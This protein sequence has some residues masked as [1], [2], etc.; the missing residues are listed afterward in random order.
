MSTVSCSDEF[1]EVAPAGSLSQTELATLS[2]LE[3]TLLGAYSMLLGRGGFY[4]AADNWVW[5]SILGGDAN[6]GT[7][8]G[9]QSQINEIQAY[10]VQTNNA[11]VKQKYQNS[12]EGVARANAVLQLIALAEDV[13]E[14]D[15]TRI[16]A[17]ARFLRGHYYFDLKKNFNNVPYVDENWDEIEP[18][19]NNQDLYPFI[20]A[21][22][23]F[24]K[25]NLPETMSDLVGL[26]E[27]PPLHIWE[28]PY[29]SRANGL[30]PKPNLIRSLMARVLLLKAK[31]THCYRTMGMPSG[32]PW[33][34]AVNRCLLPRQQPILGVLTMPTRQWY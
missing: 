26:T 12:Y 32:H 22:F 13:S 21:D 11:S 30:R 7:D 19:P 29:C 33:T 16:A 31:T 27:V 17:E 23:Q 1:L 10:N 9:D 28:K 25:A 34:I 4:S 6:K 20:E 3:G 2:G 14:A 24:A 5:G 8:A 18:V 15:K